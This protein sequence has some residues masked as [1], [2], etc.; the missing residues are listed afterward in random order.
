MRVEF[1][2]QKCLGRSGV[3]DGDPVSQFIIEWAGE[4]LIPEGV[5]VLEIGDHSEGIVTDLPVAKTALVPF[6]EICRDDSVAVE[7]GFEDGLDFG[8]GVE[9]L[10]EGFTLFTVLH[11]AIEL[12]TDFVRETSDF[13]GAG[14]KLGEVWGAEFLL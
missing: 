2:G 11:T 13:S 1:R 12:F 14:H 10:E 6:G 3:L 9:P 7:V 8:Q 4:G 5:L